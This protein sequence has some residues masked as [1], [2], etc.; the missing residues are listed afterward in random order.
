[1]TTYC[2]W[3]WFNIFSK[4]RVVRLFK[5]LAA[6]ILSDAQIIACVVLALMDFCDKIPGIQIFL[7]KILAIFL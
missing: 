2:V 5:I 6:K 7:S 3:M 4:F 1:M